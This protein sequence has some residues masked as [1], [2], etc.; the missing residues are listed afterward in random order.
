MLVYYQKIIVKITTKFDIKFKP[1]KAKE[2]NINVTDTMP[3]YLR[4]Q[5]KQSVPDIIY[6]SNQAK[7]EF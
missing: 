2:L 3:S 1:V 7:R 6:L 4:G 5:N